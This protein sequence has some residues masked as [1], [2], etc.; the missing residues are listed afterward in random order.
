MVRVGLLVADELDP[1]M[2]G[3]SLAD[4]SGKEPGSHLQELRFRY[5]TMPTVASETED[6]DDLA[7]RAIA[8]VDASLPQLLNLG[9]IGDDMEPLH[10]LLAPGSEIRG[11]LLVVG[12]VGVIATKK[13]ANRYEHNRVSASSGIEN[14]TS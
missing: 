12:G 9:D 8:T 11:P 4:W 6:H 2:D 1:L 13:G 10:S 3:T 7:C 14:A 5:I